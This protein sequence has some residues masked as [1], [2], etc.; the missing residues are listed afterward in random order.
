MVYQNYKDGC[1]PSQNGTAKNLQTRWWRKGSCA[2]QPEPAARPPRTPPPPGTTPA[3]GTP[4]APPGVSDGQERYGMEGMPSRFVYLDSP[5]PNTEFFNHNAY[6]K[7]TKHE[8]D[9]IPDLLITLSAVQ[10]YRWHGFWR[11]VQPFERIRQWRWGLIERN[12]SFEYYHY[13]QLADT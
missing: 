12:R 5:L 8:K 4:H 13:L 2:P 3:P 6:G 10:K 7:D 9:I 1:L 11:R